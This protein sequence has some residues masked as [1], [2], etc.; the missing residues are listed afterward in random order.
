MAIASLRA[1]VASS[2]SRMA[3]TRYWVMETL[4]KPHG[5]AKF[6]SNETAAAWLLSQVIG[7]SDYLH[8]RMAII[9]MT[10]SGLRR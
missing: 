5:Y 3:I 9:V 7:G 1:N 2:H 8:S 10:M 6:L 4:I